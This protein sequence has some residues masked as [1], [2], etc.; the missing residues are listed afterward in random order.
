M[1]VVMA[2]LL[3]GFIVEAYKIP[4]GSM[5]PTLIG[6][7][8]ADIQDRILVDKLSYSFRDPKRW[9]V[10][11]FR[12]PLNY[13]QNF[14]K[15]VVGVGPEE[16]RIKH[17]DLWSRSSE[18]EEWSIL[19]RPRSVQD[20]MWKRLDLLQPDGTSWRVTNDGKAWELA[21]RRIEARGDGMAG[22]RKPGSVMDRYFDGYPEVLVPLI[23]KNPK[24]N[25]P[26]AVGDLRVSSQLTC[27][28]GE[29][30]VSFELQEGLKRYLFRIPGPAAEPTARLRIEVFDNSRF[31]SGG[32]LTFEGERPYRLPAGVPTGVAVQNMDDLLELEIDGEVRLSMEVES[33]RDQAS[34]VWLRST[35]EGV[36]F[37]ELM[38]YRD[39]Y[40]L[41]EGSASY[42]IPAGHYLMLGDNTQNS[43]DSRH[44]R[45]A[46][47][48][49][50]GE[51]EE[52]R[53]LRGNY[54][55]G[56]N[57]RAVLHGEPDGPWLRLED[58]YGETHIF[59]SSRAEQ[60]L[61]LESP[62]VPREMVLGKAMAVF[63]PFN[64]ITEIYRLKW[65]N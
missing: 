48:E 32:P 60:L 41:S 6:D 62:F 65:V 51:A 13:A 10:A 47:Y 18:A 56:E 29:R 52:L 54:R 26:T 42:Q 19:R 7:E 63:W 37:E 27:L 50:Q 5:Q 14:I 21:G 31:S 8:H 44:W 61:P 22:F 55:R 2:L 64:P 30:E 40:Y 58:E 46:R 36:D 11:V 15:R 33:M 12:Y 49:V 38:V 35:G 45:F 24:P 4:T 20:S 17:G 3:K 43:S 39:V 53:N 1:A 23:S 28:P 34:S 25:L 16:F 9:E 57:P 59:P